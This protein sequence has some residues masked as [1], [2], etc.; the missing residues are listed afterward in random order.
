MSRS[1]MRMRNQDRIAVGTLQEGTILIYVTKADYD[2]LNFYIN[3]KSHDVYL[4]L[5]EKDGNSYGKDFGKVKFNYNQKAQDLYS[6]ISTHLLDIEDREIKPDHIQLFFYDKNS[7]EFKITPNNQ[8]TKSLDYMI[9][10]Q[11]LLYFEELPY[12][13]ADIASKV[14]AKVQHY[15]KDGSIG[16]CY[17]ELVEQN[18]NMWRLCKQM[19]EKHLERIDGA[20]VILKQYLFLMM[21]KSQSAIIR[22]VEMTQQVSDILMEIRNKNASLALTIINQQEIDNMMIQDCGML[23]CTMCDQLT[24]TIG[25]PFVT[26]VLKNYTKEQIREAIFLKLMD[27]RVTYNYSKDEETEVSF[28]QKQ[29]FTM[30]YVDY[31]TSRR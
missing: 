8:A 30:Y 5:I 24:R 7:N 20:E 15:G 21:D 13:L 26:V 9:W 29:N 17:N 6:V 12:P 27:L 28:E 18:C 31:K 23:F 19:R 3:E 22:I 16:E 25:N 4:T 10:D 2:E 1:F 11:N 14:I